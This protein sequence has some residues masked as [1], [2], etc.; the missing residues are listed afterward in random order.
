MIRSGN[1]FPTPLN[2]SG[3]N[4]NAAPRS[5]GKGALPFASSALSGKGRSIITGYLPRNKAL[6]ARVKAVVP[7]PVH[8]WTFIWT[9]N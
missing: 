2:M 1:L 8:H 4:R 7:Q 6:V 5:S 9:Q 3:E